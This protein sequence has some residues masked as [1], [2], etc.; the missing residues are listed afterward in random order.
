MLEIDIPFEIH[1]TT[2]VLESTQVKEFV[3]FCLLN[4]CKPLIIDLAKGDVSNQPMLSAVLFSRDVNEALFKANAISVSL[5]NTGFP[6]NRIKIEVPSA[7]FEKFKNFQPGFEKYFEW[8][9]KVVY[10]N[11]AGLNEM[12]EKHNVHLSKNSLKNESNT[13]FI[14]LREFGTKQDFEK[15][16]DEVVHKL[17]AGNWTI[18]KQE[19]EYC[20]YDSNSILDNG[21]IN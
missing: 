15:R 19:A 20:I 4:N 8:H 10:I 6:T 14:T 18:L 12:C 9:C 1:L 3:D 17:N 7:H 13:R 16:I 21:W 11:V 2:E 5:N